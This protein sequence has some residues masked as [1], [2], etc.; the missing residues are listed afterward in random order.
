MDAIG[1]CSGT[2]TILVFTG[3]GFSFAFIWMMSRFA[4]GFA[5]TAITLLLLML[6]G[7]GAV[8]IATAGSA[9]TEE[10]KNGGVATGAIFLIFGACFLAGLCCYRKSLETAIAII[11][12]A[13]DFLMDTKRIIIVSIL[14]SFVSFFCFLIWIIA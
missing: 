12:A 10:A 14:Y 9:D 7:G 6:F 13:A 4:R 3:F 1:K 11:D 8:L 2:I 5:Y